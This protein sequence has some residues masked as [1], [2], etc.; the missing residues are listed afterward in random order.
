MRISDWSSDVCS[1]DLRQRP[2]NWPRRPHDLGDSNMATSSY[3]FEANKATIFVPGYRS[4]GGGS[5]QFSNAMDS[6]DTVVRV[7]AQ[8]Y[9]EAGQEVLT[10][11]VTIST[12]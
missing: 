7:I 6:G 8:A 4:G 1:S 2:S 9:A 12:D 3:K 10:G 5:S 11:T